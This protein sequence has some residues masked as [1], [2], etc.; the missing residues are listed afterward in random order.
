VRRSAALLGALAIAFAGCGEKAEPVDVPPDTTEAPRTRVPFGAAVAA[1]PARDDEA[2]LRAF[3]E[4][5][6][7]LALENSTAWAVIQPEEGRFDFE[8]TDA[9][10]DLA[11][12]TGKR[13]RGQLVW[14]HVLPVWLTEAKRSP[15]ELRRAMVEHVR[16]IVARYRGR[17][18][19]W[20]VVNEPLNDDGSGLERS[21]WLRG[22]GEGYVADALRAA[23]EADPGAVLLLNEIAA[24]RGA[25]LAALA[26]LAG[27]L[28]ERGAPLDAVGLQNHTTTR[29]FPT[30]PEL[31]T[32]L[33]RMAQA[34]LD[35]QITEMDVVLDAGTPA[36]QARAYRVAAQACL[37]AKRC[38]GF[39]VWGVTDAHSWKGEEA[40]AL[41]FGADGEPKP[42]AR[43]VLDVL[44]A[45]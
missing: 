6:G 40:R 3:T 45:P 23:R 24:E 18:H 28:K 8:Q 34:G 44:R 13:V 27:R 32:A 12:R 36:D 17:V 25:K 5:F 38:T 14:D 42:A 26:A 21:I 39:T 43:A 10:V 11:E 1:E 2:Y 7:V 29:D 22:L 16:T 15:A 31:V 20:V 35:A 19:E 4:N 41:L 9:L 30:R 37:A 33:D